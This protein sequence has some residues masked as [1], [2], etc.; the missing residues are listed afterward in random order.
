M[1]LKLRK[2]KRRIAVFLVI[3]LLFEIVS[4]TVAFSLTS[5][6]AQPESASF[7]P[8]GTTDMVDPFTGDFNYNIPLLDVD[9]YPINIS[10]HSGITMDSEASWV[11]LGW[12]INPGS[13]NRSMRGLPDD[14]NGDLVRKEFNSKENISYGINAG[15]SGKLFGL[16]NLSGNFGLGVAYNN[17]TGYNFIQTYGVSISVTGKSSGQGALN[18]G[19]SSSADGADFSPSIS[20]SNKLNNNE[21]KALNGSASLGMSF[22]SRS[23]IKQ[24]N[25]GVNLSTTATVDK[26]TDN[27]SAGTSMGWNFAKSTYV[28]QYSF[29]YKTYTFGWGAT[30]GG[31]FGGQNGSVYLNGSYSKQKLKTKVEDI[32]SFGYMY[33][34][35]GQ[36][37]DKVL[38]DFNREKDGAFNEFTTDLPLT[39]Y[40]YDIFSVSG[41]GV[42]G[43]YRAF[44]N[45]IGYVHDSRVESDSENDN[46]SG[47]IHLGNAVHGDI[48]YFHT[49][50]DSYSSVWLDNND[51]ANLLKFSS[52]SINNLYENV[53]F[54]ESGE[55]VVDESSFYADAFENLA[56][57]IP[58]DQIGKQ[59]KTQ[60][61]FESENSTK[62]LIKNKRDHSL[63]RVKRNQYFQYINYGDYSKLAVQKSLNSLNYLLGVAKKNHIAEIITTKTDGSRYVYGLPAYNKTQVECSFSVPGSANVNKG[64]VQFNPGSDDS[65]NNSNGLDNFYSKT[66]LPAYPYAYMLTAVLSPDYVDVTGNGP[67]SDDLGNYTKFNYQKYCTDYQWRAPYGLNETTPTSRSTYDKGLSSL[68]DDDKASYTKGTKEIY[69]LTSI[70]TKNHVGIF[71]LVQRKDGWGSDVNGTGINTSVG[72]AQYMLKSIA[73]YSRKDFDTF[74]SNASPIKKVNFEYDYS[75]CPNVP[76]NNQSTTL[77]SCELNNNDKGKLTLR[78]IYF[79]YGQSK[80]GQLSPYQFDYNTLVNGSPVNYDHRAYDR[81]GNY[82]PIQSSPNPENAEYPYTEQNKANIDQYTQLWNLKS[83]QLPSGGRIE[84][85]LESDDYGFV[86]NKRAMQMVKIEA[87]S[88]TIPGPSGQLNLNNN[89]LFTVSGNNF[90]TNKGKYYLFKLSQSYINSGDATI[91]VNRLVNGIKDLYF[92][93]NVNTNNSGGYEYVSGY[94]KVMS[95]GVY[96]S[97][98]SGPY[99]YGYIKMDQTGIDDNSGITDIDFSPVSKAAWQFARLHTPRISYAINSNVN[100]NT[101]QTAFFQALKSS[102]SNI[103]QTFKGANGALANLGVGNTFDKNKSWIRLN[104]PTGFKLGGGNRVKEI[105]LK[106][107]WGSML[108]TIDPNA[109]FKYGQTYDYRKLDDINDMIISSGVATYEPSAGADENPFKLPVFGRDDSKR[110]RRLLAPDDDFYIEEPLGESFFPSPSVGYSVVKVKNLAYGNVT[111]NATGYT[112]N[113]FYTAKDF[114]TKTS[115]TLM[116]TKRAKDKPL[117]KIFNVN[118]EDYMAASQGYV[119]ELNDMHG[120]PKAVSVYGEGQVG[121][122]SGVEYRYRLTDGELNNQVPVVTNNGTIKYANV[123]IDMDMV[124]DFRESK[125][126]TAT[127]GL[128]ANLYF[129]FVG[130]FPVLVPPIIPSV[131]KETT[132][133]R[134]SVV[135]KVINRYGILNETINYDQSSSVSTRNMLWDAETGQVTL[136]KT[137]TEFNDDIYS[138]TYPAHWGYNGMGHAYRNQGLTVS[139]TTIGNTQSS[140]ID[141]SS[142]GYQYLTPGDEVLDLS[143]SG[144]LYWVVKEGNN[145]ALRNNLPAN[146]YMSSVSNQLFTIVRSGRRNMQGLNVGALTSFSCPVYIP[147]T[148][149]GTSTWPNLNGNSGII[150]ASSTEY[151]ENWNIFCNCGISPNPTFSKN[152]YLYGMVGNWRSIKQYT[153]LSLRNQTKE[154]SN[155]NIRKDGTFNYFSPFWNKPASGV[156]WSVNKNNWTSVSEVTEYSPYGFELEN[157]DPLN[158]YSSAQYGYNNSIPVAVASNAKY[159]QM[160][161]DGFEDYDYDTCKMSLHFGFKQGST[162]PALTPDVKQTGASFSDLDKTYQKYSHTGRRSI[163]VTPANGQYE[164]VKPLKKCSSN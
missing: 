6:P 8:V 122:I 55:K 20:Y 9:G 45:D 95:S 67:S 16:S 13:I 133:F 53:Y 92:R 47:E 164:L 24:M 34:Q 44:R 52:N 1:F 28:P 151:K 112:V 103:V 123:G 62:G 132:R 70:E 71:E 98:S 81:W 150:N 149:S 49:S 114:P 83:I 12:N 148:S 106:D 96:A 69:Y 117:F 120:K 33:T 155:S 105:R 159:R 2:Y 135:T 139:L 36:D 30:V 116:Q 7:E 76:N 156:V 73:L 143:P 57:R 65:Q 111:S 90:F 153:F 61:V 130:I 58:I 101:S 163:K 89:S 59:H 136:T 128:K 147:Q 127:Y 80:K 102:F 141:P 39:N 48:D 108:T 78:K 72:Q 104:N 113:E 84:V 18:L 54:K 144:V 63:G 158:R 19:L 97:T 64:L 10:Y 22:N 31:V 154:N 87:V 38:H 5:G 4:P 157:V 11:G 43:S 25:L 35:N 32:P 85:D 100:T 14:F 124:A 66:E 129:F 131:N 50:N 40:T 134:S 26:K 88:A 17:Y 42:G 115:K 79:T 15:L 86:Q 29:P 46:I 161:F 91:E 75:L 107:E 110:Q 41:Q 60:S 23:G 99:D 51:A 119:I 118:F 37:F 152:P 121:K 138:L 109:T 137:S 125:N 93:F 146:S 77:N 27:N 140:Y 160:A 162:A 74:G 126:H 3:N 142:P 82:K 21:K 56:V 94:T 68:N 145:L